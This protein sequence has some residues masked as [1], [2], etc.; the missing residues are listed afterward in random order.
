MKTYMN[1]IDREH[2]LMILIVWDYLGSWLEKTSCLKLLPLSL[3]ACTESR[4][5]NDCWRAAFEAWERG[6]KRVEAAQCE[7]ATT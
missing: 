7:T 2:H 3:Y 4:T 1:R 6:L 5:C